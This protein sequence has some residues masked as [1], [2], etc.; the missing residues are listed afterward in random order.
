MRN[1]VEM[2]GR[3]GIYPAGDLC[4]LLPGLL[5]W[6]VFMA[7]PFGKTVMLS[8]RTQANNAPMF[9]A[10]NY[11][12]LFQDS[13]Y[14]LSVKNT[15]L[16]FIPAISVTWVIGLAAARVL[17]WPVKR[18]NTFLV[19]LLVPFFLP[20]SSV[21]VIWKLIFG[22]GSVLMNSIRPNDQ[23]WKY[24]SLLLLYLWKNIG[25][26]ATVY[27]VSM[28]A[29]DGRIL[30]A[31]RSDGA[32]EYKVFFLIQFPLLRKATIYTAF[33]LM[34]CGVRFFREAYLM[35]GAYPA[36]NLFFVQHYMNLYFARLDYSRLSAAG[37]VFSA[38]ILAITAILS[39]LNRRK[40][41]DI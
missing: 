15:L 36:S 38:G 9:S 31:A 3:K 1:R 8:F 24:A 28:H 6:A 34:I 27:L 39:D 17:L 41:G 19:I 10:E 16:F 23:R 40:E 33:F 21:T 37:I 4:W 32:S 22:N 12:R 5:G 13:Y 11:L 18:K 29:I 26:T 30:D 2:K 35:F 7:F 20:A 14:L 25:I